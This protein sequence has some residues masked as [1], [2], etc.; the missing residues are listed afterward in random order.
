[1]PNEW[2]SIVVNAGGLGAVVLVIYTNQNWMREQ[3]K[4]IEENVNN[5]HSRIDNILQGKKL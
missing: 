4:R 5:A 3:I 2:F 1:M